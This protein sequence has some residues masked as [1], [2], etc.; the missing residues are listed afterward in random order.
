MQYKHTL[1]AQRRL[2][3]PDTELFITVG[4][5]TTKLQALP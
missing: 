4:V 2:I 1:S 3:K 5:R